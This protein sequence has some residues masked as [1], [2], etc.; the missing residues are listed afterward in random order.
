MATATKQIATTTNLGI[1]LS[2]PIIVCDGEPEGFVEARTGTLVSEG[3]NIWRKTQ[4]YSKVGWVLFASGSLANPIIREVVLLNRVKATFVGQ[5]GDVE[6][7]NEVVGSIDVNVNNGAQ[8][9]SLE[10]YGDVTHLDV[11][12]AFTVFIFDPNLGSDSTDLQLPQMSVTAKNGTTVPTAAWPWVQTSGGK[13]ID[14]DS[15]GM[16]LYFDELLATASFA[17]KII[18]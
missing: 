17:L 3:N 2:R 18:F 10:I 13:L 4:G 9:L 15:N 16:A 6:T 14:V 1:H 11:D 7:A 5:S 8:L 12:G